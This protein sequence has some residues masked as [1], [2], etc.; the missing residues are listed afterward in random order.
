MSFPVP[1]SS[2]SP[3]PSTNEISQNSQNSHSTE[4]RPEN[5]LPYISP[6]ALVDSF[7][8]RSR[9]MK[10]NYYQPLDPTAIKPSQRRENEK[11]EEIQRAMEEF[12][13]EIR[14]SKMKYSQK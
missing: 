2:F 4:T 10:F 1:S 8:S 11:N 9:Q 12:D 14:R 13:E 7:K 6:G 3:P 5:F